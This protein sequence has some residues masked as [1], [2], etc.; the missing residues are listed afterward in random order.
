M[1]MRCLLCGVA[2]IEKAR[3]EKARNEKARNPTR[4]AGLPST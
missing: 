2:I 4:I 3:N 1:L